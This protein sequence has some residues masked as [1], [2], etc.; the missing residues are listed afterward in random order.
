MAIVEDPEEHEIAALMR[1]VPSIHGARVL[2]VGSGYGRLT[3]R[4]VGAAK[5]VLAIDPDA[6]A[7]DELA[8]DLPH[9]TARVRGI[10]EL[11]LNQGSV[12]IVLFAW[13]L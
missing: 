7:I 1:V 11:T 2:E 5:S 10:E 3:A 8:R 4:Y 9:V 13:S 12:D 6:E